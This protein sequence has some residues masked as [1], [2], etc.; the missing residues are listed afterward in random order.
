MRAVTRSTRSLRPQP[1]QAP[2]TG[3][4]ALAPHPGLTLAPAPLGLTEQT[5][6][7]QG[8]AAARDAAVWVGQ[9]PVAEL[10]AATRKT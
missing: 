7:T 4:T 9:V 3:V 8:V 2:A 5:E 6:G 1:I 10:A